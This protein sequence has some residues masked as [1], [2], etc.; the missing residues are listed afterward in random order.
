[1][2]YGDILALNTVLAYASTYVTYPIIYSFLVKK[3]LL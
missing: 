2:F 1:M 3:K